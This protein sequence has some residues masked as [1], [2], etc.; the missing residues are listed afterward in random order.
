MVNLIKS[1][2]YKL[3]NSKVYKILAAYMIF[4]VICLIYASFGYTQGEGFKWIYLVLEGRVYGFHHNV[5]ADVNNI[6]GVEVFV[7]TLGTAPIIIGGISYLISFLI[8]DEYKNGTYKNILTYGHKRKD[9][10]IAKSVALSI[11]IAIIVFSSS[12]IALFLGTIIYG[13]GI[14]F[15]INQIIDIMKWLSVNTVIFISIISIISVVATIF[16]SGELSLLF[17]I[18]FILSP[19][20][21]LQLNVVTLDI[22][23]YHPIFMLMD[24]CIKMPNNSLILQILII[25]SII[26]VL[27]T[28]LGSYIFKKQ[29][30][31]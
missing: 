8:G 17:A 12:L 9:L 30:I 1:E 22:L 25:C 19:Y 20:I 26:T 6:R 4:M 10:Y 3:L 31:R 27:F 11:G 21:L 24:T 15:E 28:T 16:K 13:W 23:K 2:S 18:I 29:N 5:Y 14:P 7:S